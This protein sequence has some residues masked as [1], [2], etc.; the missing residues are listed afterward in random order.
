[1]VAIGRGLGALYGR[2]GRRR[3][4]LA[5]RNL[6]RALGDELDAAGRRRVLREMWRQFGR[7]A[8]EGLILDRFHR[9]DL[10]TVVTEEGREHLE[11]ALAKGKGTFF[12]SGHFG[13]WE[14][15]LYMNGLR[16]VPLDL[17][18]RP[19]DNPAL[20]RLLSG[21]RSASGNRVVHKRQAVRGMLKALSE[22][23][24]VAIMIDQN[25]AYGSRVFVPYFGRL[26]ST[27]PSLALLALRTGAPVVPVF[28]VP[29]RPLGYHITYCP[30]VEVQ[31]TGDQERDV[32]RITA[33]CTRVLE[34][35]VRRHPECWLWMH[36]RWKTRPRPEGISHEQEEA[37]P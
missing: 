5:A 24:G 21:I 34:D 25:V 8:A 27:T 31:A 11:A 9:G 3:R 2:L 33:S 15:A 35:W 10:G 32:L 7:V 26:A 28:S 19:L 16:G 13:N 20:E 14:L 36:D 30:P 29:R 12:F 6:E 4:E 37:L 23:R 17:I 18:V 1:V 22:G